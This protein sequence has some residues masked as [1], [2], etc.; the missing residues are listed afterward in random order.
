[1]SAEPTKY[2]ENAFGIFMSTAIGVDCDLC[3]A[4]APD[5]F[6]LPFPTRMKRK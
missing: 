5:N 6:R 3:I 2:P 4:T 1:M